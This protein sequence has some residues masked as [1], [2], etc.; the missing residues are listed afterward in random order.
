MPSGT[1][2]TSSAGSDSEHSDRALPADIIG[3]AVRS[4][5]ESQEN[6]NDEKP[7]S[8]VD[9][10]ADLERQ[11]KAIGSD[12][13]V[14]APASELVRAPPAETPPHT[15]LTQLVRES[16]LMK[17]APPSLLS[18]C[19]GS[20]TLGEYADDRGAVARRL[21]EIPAFLLSEIV[22]ADILKVLDEALAPTR[23]KPGAVEPTMPDEVPAVPV[24]QNDETSTADSCSRPFAS[25]FPESAAQAIDVTRAR[26]ALD[27]LSKQGFDRFRAGREVEDAIQY[28]RAIGYTGSASQ[29]CDDLPL[30]LAS[31]EK[32]LSAPDRT[33]DGQ[34]AADTPDLATRPP[35]GGGYDAARQQPQSAVETEPGEN[36]VE[37]AQSDNAPHAMVTIDD[38]LDAAYISR[39]LSNVRNAYKWFFQE[40]TIDDALNRRQEFFADILTLNNVGRVTTGEIDRLLDQYTDGQVVLVSTNAVPPPE[41]SADAMSALAL[42]APITQVLGVHPISVRLESALTS[43]RARALRVRD[44]VEDREGFI[45]TFHTLNNVGQ[46][47]IDEACS[48]LSEHIDAIDGWTDSDPGDSD[49]DQSENAKDSESKLE[50]EA[51]KAAK[52]A[53]RES[54]RTAVASLPEKQAQVLRWRYGLEGE[55]AH[56]LQE[57]ADKVL[58]TRERVRQVEQ[59]GLRQLKKGTARFALTA[60]I[61]AEQQGQWEALAGREVK[62]PFDELSE[63]KRALDPLFV[64]AI[65]AQVGGVREW[66]DGFATK[67]AEGWTRNILDAERREALKTKIEAT[68]DAFPLPL[69][70]E[71]LLRE[72]GESADAQTVESLDLK[73]L[74]VFE[75]YLCKG[76]L[77]VRAQRKVRL[78]LVARMVA[79]S[80]LFDVGTLLRAYRDLVPEDDAGSRLIQ[81]QLEE[82]PHL[83]APVFDGIWLVLPLPAGDLHLDA[84]PFEESAV[85]RQGEFSEDSTGAA[86]WRILA[87][88]GPTRQSEL[89]SS[90]VDETGA[91][92]TGVTPVLLMNPCFRR[93]APG[94]FSL[95]AG[96]DELSEN[97]GKKLLDEPQC[98]TFCLLRHCG[99]PADYFPA[100]GAEFE[101]GLTQWAHSNA[102][103]DLY[104]SLISVIEPVR[105]PIPP[106]LAAQALRAKEHESRWSIGFERK[107]PL[108]QRFIEPRRFLALLA[109][110]S[111]FGWIGWCAI[112]RLTGA[113][114]ATKDA[115]DVLAFLVLAGLAEP[116]EDW[117]S[118]H[119]ATPLATSVFRAAAE[120]IHRVGRLDWSDEVLA[121]ILDGIKPPRDSLGWVS[122]DEASAA[123][124]AWRSGELSIGRAFARG[125]AAPVDIEET[126]NSP[127]W[128]SVFGAED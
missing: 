9:P 51:A 92:R 97:L 22:A 32:E 100:W 18:A 83:F 86:I 88:N 63:R 118:S 2:D 122:P 66:L 5:E 62:V 68:A 27:V 76:H 89:V 108:G 42:D 28:L 65:D 45:R 87:T 35:N 125:S 24:A 23:P 13:A 121:P 128:Q 16:V 6:G 126:F 69:P 53:P 94:F 91:A 3:G 77:G 82:A 44:F 21:A 7:Q 67:I 72:M 26:A 119:A 112:N 55:T 93:I 39:R 19:L 98:R 79:R 99:A 57:I 46:K 85:I 20:L 127:E 70:L 60:F 110:L 37:L 75:G 120:L 50:A 106:E 114:L 96:R 90:V 15:L 107:D 4:H 1:D 58:V 105:W 84:P 17:S 8:S 52:I 102:P 115:A 47:T 48:I 123:I 101:M 71:F 56:T 12:E 81:M 11:P 25:R 14:A 73:D 30:L 80:G 33:I 43:D 34:G 104:R 124:E 10:Q 49:G 116:Q 74:T 41:E 117:Q 40:W 111:V 29:A 95:Y 61:T 54:L 103:T 36:L 64:L 38:L 78:H 109:H 113:A 31:C 59:K